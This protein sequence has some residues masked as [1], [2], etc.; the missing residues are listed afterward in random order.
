MKQSA[1]IALAG[2]VE[3][4]ARYVGGEYG[5]IAPKG[6]AALRFLLAYPDVY[7][8]GMS[9]LGLQILYGLINSREAFS[10][11]RVFAPWPDYQ[12]W[13]QSRGDRLRS[14][15]SGRPMAEFDVVGFSLQHELTYTNVL[16]MLELGGLPIRSSERETADPL[17]IAGGPCAVAPEPMADFI[18]A[19][20]VG[21]GEA[22]VVRFLERI[23]ELNREDTDRESR[24]FELAQ[25]PGV[26]V[27]RF[28]AP[29]YGPDG[30]L[31]SLQP[32]REG[33]PRSIER[34][35][36]D[37]EETFVPS[38]LI[39]PNLRAVHDRL[40]VEVK[41]GCT[42]GCRFCQ[43]GYITRP[44]RERR[45]ETLIR[46][47]EEL[48]QRS[49]YDQITLLSLST[50]D[51]TAL[52]R[53][54]RDLMEPCEDHHV[55]LALPSLRADGFDPQVV[56]RLARVKRTGLTFAPEVA[57]ERLR[58]IINKDVTPE[59]IFSALEG[60]EGLGYNL[61]KFYFMVGLPTEQQDDLE[62][63]VELIEQVGRF[64]DRHRLPRK[65]IHVALAG[66]IPKPHTPFQGLAQEGRE[67]LQEKMQWVKHELQGKQKNV[68]VRY[69][70]ARASFMEAVLARGDRRLGGAIERAFRHGCQ[71]DAWNDLFSFNHW[72]RAFEECGIDPE[73]YA[74]RERPEQ[75]SFPWDV[76]DVGVSKRFLREECARALAGETTEDCR[77]GDC[78]ACGLPRGEQCHRLAEAAQPDSAPGSPRG[79]GPLQRP[80]PFPQSDI[81]VIYRVRYS[82][83][84]GLVLVSHLSLVRLIDQ[85]IRRAGLKSALTQG[86][87]PKPKRMFSE[88][89]PVGVASQAELV[90]LYLYH[91]GEGGQLV[92]W[93]NRFV[94]EGLRFLGANRIRE[95]RPRLPAAVEAVRYRIE[96]HTAD[97]EAAETLRERIDRIRRGESF[98]VE[99]LSRK[100]GRRTPVDLASRLLD[101][102]C[103]FDPQAQLLRMD[104]TWKTG[105]NLPSLGVREVLLALWAQAEGATEVLEKTEVYSFDAT[106]MRLEPLV[107]RTQE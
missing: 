52:N 67:Q 73:G 32:E 78:Y 15:E 68:E 59:A 31:Q 104:L 53:L 38:S 94:P 11:E 61:V 17:V 1:L 7:E 89:L 29:R 40:V 22:L 77:V 71:F 93:L 46:M 90:D 66:F 3:N 96:V 72:M 20:L 84:T 42:R 86:Y 105:P 33:V 9:Y 14:L 79:A 35:A 49:G 28:Y 88:P 30:W 95:G 5:S 64:W 45:P 48:L 8:V 39:V 100:S 103:V 43:A 26:Y 36:V 91:L 25:L 81:P 44:N 92:A 101:G 2:V 51:Y 54:M 83:T 56:Q 76:I 34:Q 102:G 27:P 107:P 41:R 23:A 80:P 97:R 85:V 10:C 37:L 58:R 106:E 16:R 75:E 21:D 98:R 63:I 18:D 60:L 87:N 13:L 62:A 4:P 55:A 74:N 69:A 50:G 99:H 24:L 12:R 6:N 70:D 82:K 57:S 65:R 47:V 19:F